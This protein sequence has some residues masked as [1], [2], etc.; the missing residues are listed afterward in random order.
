MRKSK[1]RRLKTRIIFFVLLLFTIHCSLFTASNAESPKRII[2]LAPSITEILFAAGLEDRIV[3]VTNFCDYPEQAK[4]KPKIGGIANPSLEAVVSLK[5][6]IVVMTMDGNPREFQQ[7]LDAMGIKTYVFRSHR[8]SELPDGIRK[9]G[10]A[11]DEKKMFEDLALRIEQSLDGFNTAKANT[12]GKM[13]FVIWPEPLIVAGP[14]TA[15][16]DAINLLG[17]IN[18]AEDAKGRYPKYSIEEIIR[19]SPDVIF[20]GRGK[21]MDRISRKLLKRLSSV[22]AV[23]NK[24]VFYVSD[25]LYRLGPRVISGLKELEEHLS[26]KK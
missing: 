20:F 12:S 25:S 1:D 8:I 22:P 4:E 10:I 7:R 11:L 6:D 3:G 19:R 17:G 26:K 2:S 24:K 16:N 14:G 21:G 9:I 5:P 15:I 23:K 13:L 18:I